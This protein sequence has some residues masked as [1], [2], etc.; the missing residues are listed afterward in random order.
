MS[1]R[2]CGCG[3]FSQIMTIFRV[4]PN[5]F[6]WVEV[7]N[8]GKRRAL[9]RMLICSGL[10][11][12]ITL[13]LLFS[14]ILFFFVVFHCFIWEGSPPPSLLYFVS[15][16]KKCLL[17]FDFG[18]RNWEL[19]RPASERTNRCAASSFAVRSLGPIFLRLDAKFEEFFPY[20]FSYSVCYSS[21]ATLSPCSW[22]SFL[23]LLYYLYCIYP[24]RRLHLWD[25][26]SIHSAYSHRPCFLVFPKEFPFVMILSLSNPKSLVLNDVLCRLCLVDA[27]H[28]CCSCWLAAMR[29]CLLVYIH[30]SH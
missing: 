12:D 10:R 19:T 22:S 5:V 28:V 16:Q 7:M 2:V 9:G 1:G 25:S 17:W 26:Y 24:S 13:K 4:E 18:C 3:Y 21:C 20:C 8:D 30:F 14:V 15:V 29:P 23:I 27:S 11:A 6:H